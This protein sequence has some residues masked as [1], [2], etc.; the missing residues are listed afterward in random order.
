MGSPNTT[1]QDL[2]FTTSA[3]KVIQSQHNQLYSVVM[4]LE[5]FRC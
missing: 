2:G 1:S 3:A 4:T 5:Y